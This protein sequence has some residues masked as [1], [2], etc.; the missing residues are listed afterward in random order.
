MHWHRIAMMQSSHVMCKIIPLQVRLF[1]EENE[2]C[3]VKTSR[4]VKAVQA[5]SNFMANIKVKYYWADMKV[6]GRDNT[7][8]TNK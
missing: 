1:V 8:E 6:S 5:L 2:I 7:T 4:F 3:A